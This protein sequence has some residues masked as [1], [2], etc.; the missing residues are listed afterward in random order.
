MAKKKIKI[1]LDF[2]HGGT[3]WGANEFGLIEKVMN[4]IT[5]LECKEIL[6]KYDIEVMTSRDIDKTVSLAERVRM[7]NA[8]GADYFI[9]IHYN[10]GGGDGVESIHSIYMG[11]GEQLAKA[12]VS[13][14]NKHT[15]QNLRPRAT[16]SK[17]GSDKKDYYY[18]IKYT[19]MDCIIVESGFIDSEDRY[20]FDTQEEQKAMGRAIAY[21]I[22][23]FLGIA[24]IEEKQPVPQIPTPGAKYG[25]VT[26]TSLNVRENRGTQYKRIGEL[27]QGTRVKLCYK[28]NGWWSID[29]GANVGYISAEFIKEEV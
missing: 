29:F 5:G 24:L 20:L 1:F 3:D 17:V 22:L 26:A 12:V 21:G 28:L 4:L 18:V 27:K 10:A 19:N 9:S 8:W 16:Y 14:I 6:Q 7:A 23:N 25:I 13:S 2:G 15:G 11:K